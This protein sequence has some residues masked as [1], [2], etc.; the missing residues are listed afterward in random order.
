[1]IT[2]KT[3]TQLVL[4]LLFVVLTSKPFCSSKR[5]NDLK[6]L[7]SKISADYF[8]NL[9]STFE[10]IYPFNAMLHKCERN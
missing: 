4:T 6:A 9:P 10:V 3:L 5:L 8:T 1:M 7:L 2:C